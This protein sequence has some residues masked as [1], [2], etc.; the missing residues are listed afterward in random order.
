MATSNFSDI[1]TNPIAV[2][3]LSIVA[4]TIA[5][6]LGCVSMPTEDGN[7]TRYVFDPLQFSLGRPQ[8]QQMNDPCF[9]QGYTGQKQGYMDPQT[10]RLMIYEGC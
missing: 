6:N 8:D 7:T 4:F 3:K 10:G 9:R 1:V 5:A 2:A